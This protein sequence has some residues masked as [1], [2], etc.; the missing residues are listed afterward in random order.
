MTAAKRQNNA[1][2]AA[3]ILLAQNPYRPLPGLDQTEDDRQPQAP[4]DE[5][6]GEERVEN[7]FHIL[8]AYATAVIFN[9]QHGIG[10]SGRS[11]I[12]RHGEKAWKFGSQGCCR[13]YSDRAGALADGLDAVG[14]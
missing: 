13:R 12:A 1:K 7:L 9:R 6:G 10:G 3:L 2:D 4:A 5:F 11:P 8:A 14:D